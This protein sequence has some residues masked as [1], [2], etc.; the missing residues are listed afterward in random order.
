MRDNI[1]AVKKRENR[2]ICVKFVRL[3]MSADFA[4]SGAG[5]YRL[6]VTIGGKYKKRFVSHA[7][8]R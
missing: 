1:L 2:E 6:S 8:V 7:V 5:M 3:G 4:V